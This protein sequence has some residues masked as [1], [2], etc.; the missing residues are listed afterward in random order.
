[1]KAKYLF[2]LIA[3]IAIIASGCVKD[4][5]YVGP[6][7]IKNMSIDPQA[8]GTTDQVTVTVRVTDLKECQR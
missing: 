8:P 6:P 4:E 2:M 7:T 1:M 3:S 5:V